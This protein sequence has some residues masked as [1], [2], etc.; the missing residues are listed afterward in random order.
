MVCKRSRRK[1]GVK[2][3]GLHSGRGTFAQCA[4]HTPRGHERE[5]AL[6]SPDSRI[7]YRWPVDRDS[8]FEKS[9]LIYDAE[10]HLIAVDYSRACRSDEEA[11]ACPAALV[12]PV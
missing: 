5:E 7:E 11:S 9:T 10:G 6:R 3:R 4:A 12:H 8:G 2:G 1:F